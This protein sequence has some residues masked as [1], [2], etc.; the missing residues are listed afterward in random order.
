MFVFC[1]K[2]RSICSIAAALG[3]ILGSYLL[4]GDNSR[5]IV[6]RLDETLRSLLS[7]SSFESFRGRLSLSPTPCALIFLFC[8]FAFRLVVL[9]RATR[10]LCTAIDAKAPSGYKKTIRYC[11]S[12]PTRISRLFE[13]PDHRSPCHACA[14]RQSSSPRRPLS[15]RTLRVAKNA[16]L[17]GD[18]HNNARDPILDL[19]Y[20]TLRSYFHHVTLYIFELAYASRKSGVG[21]SLK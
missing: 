14:T 10:P 19:E 8:F 17:K 6:Y 9:S 15:I 18:T 16:N 21:N 13:T 12:L 7:A 2:I 4:R 3:P 5:V 20:R 11:A 1:F